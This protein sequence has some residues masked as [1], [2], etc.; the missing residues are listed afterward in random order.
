MIARLFFLMALLLV[1]PTQSWAANI[2]EPV[3]QDE[4]I[5]VLAAMFGD[6]K[7]FGAGSDGFSAAMLIFNGGVMIIG[8][9]LMIYS[10]VIGTIGTAHDGEM[11]GKKYSSVWIPLRT[12]IATALVVPVISGSYCLMQFIVGWLILQ[13]VGLADVIWMAYMNGTSLT[14][15]AT[16]GLGDS[17]YKKVAWDVFGSAICVHGY[18]EVTKQQIK[19]GSLLYNAKFDMTKVTA[20]DKVTWN[21]GVSSQ[22][23][24][25]SADSCG[26]V[27]YDKSTK[28]NAAK[29]TAAISK[30][31]SGSNT[32]NSGA[33]GSKI[34]F[35]G[36]SRQELENKL[37]AANLKGV[38][39]VDDFISSI[40]STANM[41][42]QNPGMSPETIKTNLEQA[43][44]NYSD[45]MK[46]EAAVLLNGAFNFDTLKT[47]AAQ[48]GWFLAGAWYMKIVNLMDLANAI[49]NMGPKSTGTNGLTNHVYRDRFYILYGPMLENVA[50]HSSMTM[51]I[52]ENTPDRDIS[53]GGSVGFWGASGKIASIA[54]DAYM[55][56]KMPMDEV[57][58]SVFK[59][60]FGY[61]VI[62][63]EDHPMM[64]MKSMGNFLF[65]VAASLVTGFLVISKLS[66]MNDTM[67]GLKEF[68]TIL[69][70]IFLPLCIG[71][72][73]TLNFVM[74]MMPFMIWLG[75]IL[76]WLILCVEALI[77]APMWAIMHLSMSGDDMVGTGAQGYKLV[78]SLMLRPA[79]MIFG[80]IA[81]VSIVHVVG[82]FINRVFLNVYLLSQQDFGF[83][84][85]MFG[86]LAV[87]VLYLGAMWVLI[88]RSMNIVHQIPDQLLQWFG[89][90]GS[91]L[92]EAAQSVGGLQSQAFA[93]TAA[94][95]GV[96]KSIPNA[97]TQYGQQR[98][99]RIQNAASARSAEQNE[100]QQHSGMLDKK[101]GA[102][103]GELADRFIK[104]EQADNPGGNNK[105]GMG[106]NNDKIQREQQRAMI[107]SQIENNSSAIS[108]NPESSKAVAQFNKNV[109]SH[110]D[111][112]KNSSFGDAVNANFEKSFDQENGVGSYQMAQKMSGTDN[113]NATELVN[114]QE[115]RKAAS[116]LSDLSGNIRQSGGDGGKVMTEA[117]KSANDSLPLAT[118]SE[119]LA[120]ITQSVDSQVKDSSFHK[121]KMNIPKMGPNPSSKP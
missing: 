46:A 118:V 7:V 56:K 26:I 21:F 10:L 80:F 66:S 101:A 71:L 96:V 6:L 41:F 51:G 4:S 43:A 91:Q 48:E 102:G 77:A 25:F 81:S 28:T 64:V 117:I 69:M 23:S 67:K 60:T 3:P 35:N 49:T 53:A 33:L 94:T 1:L 22:D 39:Y 86:L 58:K 47:N 55:N 103:A 38:A 110:M 113:M 76:A 99:Q 70:M 78:L 42:I 59:D 79:L 65:K 54:Y 40:D 11:M 97:V 17:E 120:S 27:T 121:Q 115:F 32:G 37:S 105:V 92:G 16:M 9:V 24:G 29:I 13:G 74:P 34:E 50:A 12:V 2:F 82:Q 107:G 63:K 112:V 87:P 88:I 114:N 19:E 104:A 44:Q 36:I 18:N 93:A 119:K 5:R 89:G 62:Q 98:F 106:S 95:A 57:M 61:F 31:S 85:M 111:T 52:A 84:T 20:V 30:A 8:G 72:G 14:Q 83:M 73:F 75:C 90:G 116:I 108:A 45:K 109:K 15:S 100:I 68:L